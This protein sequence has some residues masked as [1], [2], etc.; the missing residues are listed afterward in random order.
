MSGNEFRKWRRN[1]DITL[2]KVAKTI[3]VDKSTISRW[4][5]EL[6]NISE[7]L[8]NKFMDFVKANSK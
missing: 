6:I 7:T 4:E 2:E 8:Y 1:E 3:K 5:H